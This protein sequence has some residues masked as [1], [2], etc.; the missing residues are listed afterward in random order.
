MDYLNEHVGIIVN[1]TYFTNAYTTNNNTPDNA[2]P[3]FAAIYF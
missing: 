2:P 3:H 1:I